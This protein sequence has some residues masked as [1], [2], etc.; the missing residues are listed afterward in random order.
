MLTPLNAA[1]QAAEINSRLRIAAFLAQCGHESLDFTYLREL[2]SGDAYEGRKDLGNTQPGDGHRYRGRGP[3]QITGRANYQAFAGWSGLDCVAHPE[4]L[5][6]PE[7]G[8]LASAWFWTVNH[9]NQWAD[10][11]DVDGMSD[12]INRGRKTTAIGDA[13]G[14][15]D[16][17][18][19]YKVA[20][21]AL[22]DLA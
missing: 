14:Y 15:A 2:A 3:I 21:D 22:G 17:L 13:N 4:L 7:H 18:A 6:A 16:R 12:V 5:E 10:K 1:M 20:Y 19:R 11:G 8:A 9:V